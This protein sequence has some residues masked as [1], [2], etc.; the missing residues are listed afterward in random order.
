MRLQ[1]PKPQKKHIKKPFFV[2]CMECMRMFVCAE[3]ENKDYMVSYS[4][5]C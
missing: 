5:K 4:F 2:K 1:I 3:R